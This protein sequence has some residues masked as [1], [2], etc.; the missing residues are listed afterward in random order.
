MR[1]NSYRLRSANTG[2]GAPG[3]EREIEREREREVDGRLECSGGEALN[4]WRPRVLFFI[5]S[6][7]VTGLIWASVGLG[8]LTEADI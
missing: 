2:I 8:L 1:S 4:E 3:V 7:S 6:F 5:Y